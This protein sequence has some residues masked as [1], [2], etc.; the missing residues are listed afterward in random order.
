MQRP[1]PDARGRRRLAEDP[2]EHE[3]QLRAH[4]RLLARGEDVDDAVHRLD[5]AVRVERREGEVARLG[6]A[7]R[8]LDRLEVAHLADEDDVRVLAQDG[9]QRVRERV[10]V[11]VQLALVHDA[12]L[13]RVEELDRVLDRDD[14]PRLLAVDLVDHRRERRGLARARRARHEDEAARLVAE[15][16]DDVRDAELA[17]AEDLV[18]DLA[19][20]GRDGAALQE[21][22]AAEAREALDAEGEVELELFLEAVLLDVREDRVGELLRLGDGQRRV[23][24]RDQIPVHP[25]HRGRV[26][27]DV[28][29][30]PT[31]L[32]ER[33]EELVQGHRHRA[34]PPEYPE[35]I[36]QRAEKTSRRAAGARG[37]PRPTAPSRGRL[38]RSTSGRP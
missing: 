3:R 16:L 6:D 32:D 38:P 24:E 34:V 26:R 22:V 29:V 23:V 14:V 28:E 9:A 2:L 37:E 15:R 17:E 1:L 36:R 5:G 27:R 11:G 30:G 7:E 12:A 19:E 21:A 18:G 31:P 8:A 13:V 33:L 35:M 25:D 4:L 20:D 10:R